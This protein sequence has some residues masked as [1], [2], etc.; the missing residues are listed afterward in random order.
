MLGVKYGTEQNRRLETLAT[1]PSD[2][3]IS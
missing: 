3:P 1:P 2:T